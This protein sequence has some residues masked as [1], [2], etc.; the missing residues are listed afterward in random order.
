[1]TSHIEIYPP[2]L[3]TLRFRFLDTSKSPADPG[4][5]VVAL[6]KGDIQAVFTL[7]SSP[8]ITQEATGIYK[9]TFQFL[10]EHWG[11]WTWHIEGGEPGD[12]LIPIGF[13][14][15]ATGTIRVIKPEVV[16]DV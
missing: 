14:K 12:T 3:V 5:V 4:R 6:K 8:N 7:G 13:L 1:M 10:P 11:E 15:A 9:A 16:I 2:G